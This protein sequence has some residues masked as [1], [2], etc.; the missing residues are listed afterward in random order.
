MHA[1]EDTFLIHL[2]ASTLRSLRCVR[3]LQFSRDLPHMDVLMPRRQDA[4]S[5]G[6][7]WMC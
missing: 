4:E 1:V 5:G 7:T 2:L 3:I 6:R